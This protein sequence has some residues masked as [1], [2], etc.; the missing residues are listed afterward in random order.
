MSSRAQNMKNGPYAIG[1]AENE[2]ESAKH[3]KGT[4]RHWYRRKRNM[5]TGPDAPGTTENESGSVKD[6]KVS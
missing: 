3:E 2:F 4:L 5:K 6:E 1:T